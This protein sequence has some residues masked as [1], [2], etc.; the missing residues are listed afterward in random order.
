[1]MLLKNRKIKLNFLLVLTITVVLLSELHSSFSLNANKRRNKN[2]KSSINNDYAEV[3]FSDLFSSNF[4]TGYMKKDSK[5]SKFKKMIVIKPESNNG[6]NQEA[7]RVNLIADFTTLHKKEVNKLGLD[8]EKK[9]YGFE[10]EVEEIKFIP[11]FDDRVGIYFIDKINQRRLMIIK[12]NKQT[13]LEH[14]DIFRTINK[15]EKANLESEIENLVKGNNENWWSTYK[16]NFEIT[17]T[18]DREGYKKLIKKFKA[19]K[20]SLSEKMNKMIA[21]NKKYL[22]IKFYILYHDYKSNIFNKSLKFKEQIEVNQIV[23][24]SLFFDSEVIGKEDGK[25]NNLVKA[26]ITIMKDDS[27]TPKI[28]Y[29]I[30]NALPYLDIPLN[31]KNL[32]HKIVIEPVFFRK[33]LLSNYILL[34]KNG[35]AKSKT[36]V[37]RRNLVD[38][39][40][41]YMEQLDEDVRKKALSYL[42]LFAV[43]RKTDYFMFTN[44]KVK[45]PSLQELSNL[46]ADREIK[47]QNKASLDYSEFSK[48]NLISEQQYYDNFHYSIDNLDK[49]LK[50]QKI[51]LDER[52]KE[53]FTQCKKLFYQPHLIKDR[54]DLD[55]KFY[56]L[57]KMLEWL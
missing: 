48:N 47:E 6:I 43:D 4:L 15:D 54:E 41:E 9:Y 30:E 13:D 32:Q 57:I 53:F 26:F 16:Q 22:L 44:F 35:S 23:N 29:L 11:F 8:K 5:E 50:E 56:G 14:I 33:A 28:P 20:N 1:M 2:K 36:A 39:L 3:T 42:I 51:I 17:R 49:L 45:E 25:N 18:N 31:D 19:F 46:K 34:R 37:R 7:N 27:K 10:I 52:Q 38:Y 24:K 40:T 55:V 12:V 21:E